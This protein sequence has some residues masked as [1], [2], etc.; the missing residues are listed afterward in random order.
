LEQARKDLEQ[1]LVGVTAKDLRESVL[2]R[3]DVRVRVNEILNKFD[4]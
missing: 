4:F 3:E 2:V 1:A